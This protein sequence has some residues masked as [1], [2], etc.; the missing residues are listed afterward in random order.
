MLVTVRSFCLRTTLSLSPSC[1]SRVSEMVLRPGLD[2]AERC[3]LAHHKD[4]TLAP[5]ILDLKN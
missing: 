3:I 4:E 1:H 5:G 2:Q